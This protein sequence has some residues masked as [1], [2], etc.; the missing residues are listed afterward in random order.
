MEDMERFMN[1]PIHRASLIRVAENEVVRSIVENI[2]WSIAETRE[3]FEDDSDDSDSVES[4]ITRVDEHIMVSMDTMI[5]N[6]IER[7]RGDGVEGRATIFL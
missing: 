3:E 4:F 1:N 6:E 5:M 7:Q 2:I